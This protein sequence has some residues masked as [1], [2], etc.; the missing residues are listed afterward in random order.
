MRRA[1]NSLGQYC[2]HTSQPATGMSRHHRTSGN[3]LTIL[4]RR[5]QTGH[6]HPFLWGFTRMSSRLAPSKAKSTTF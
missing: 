2:S 1:Q 5:P 4:Q 6:R 3:V